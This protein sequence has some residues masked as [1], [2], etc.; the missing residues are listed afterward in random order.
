MASIAMLNN[1]RVRI[2]I[3]ME[4]ILHWLVISVK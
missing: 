4:K 3:F 2:T 1:Q